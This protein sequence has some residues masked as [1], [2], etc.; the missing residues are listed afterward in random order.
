MADKS[1][2]SGPQDDGD[3]SGSRVKQEG[4]PIHDIFAEDHA[5]GGVDNLLPPNMPARA[6]EA[7]KVLFADPG[8]ASVSSSSGPAA[9]VEESTA[10]RARVE[11]AC[12]SSPLAPTT[13]ADLGTEP[14]VYVAGHL[15][16]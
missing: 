1:K 9:R 15:S 2:T 5:P 6:A 16:Q 3:E 12:V 13:I 14:L 10:K 7:Q 11:E 8:E 4:A